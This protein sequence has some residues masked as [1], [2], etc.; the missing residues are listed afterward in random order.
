MDATL[1]DI[2][3]LDY[4]MKLI[5]LNIHKNEDLKYFIKRLEK[6]LNTAKFCLPAAEYNP[7]DLKWLVPAA[8]RNHVCIDTYMQGVRLVEQMHK[9]VTEFID[10][11]SKEMDANGHMEDSPMYTWF[12]HLENDLCGIPWDI[13]ISHQ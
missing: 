11:L 8:S 4:D 3:A 13:K 10:I 7:E 9:Q 2:K 5:G 6:S 12:C 1:T